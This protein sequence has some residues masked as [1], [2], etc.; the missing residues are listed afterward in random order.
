LS[1]EPERR[2]ASRRFGLFPKYAAALMGLVGGALVLSGLTE[3]GLSYRASMGTTA[4]LQ[5]SEVRAAAIR[6]EQYLEGIRAQVTEVSSL[7]WESGLLDVRDRR[8]EFHRLL[9]EL[10][11]SITILVVSHDLMV[12]SG[13]ANSV[14]CVN[15]SLH[16]HDK[17]E[18][19]ADMIDMMYRCAHDESC[20]V[21]LVSHG[22]P[23]R[24]LRRHGDVRHD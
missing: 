14:A 2:A 6:I 8:E 3:M 4:E 23:H 21:E 5:R 10:N 20:P 16:Y 7:P 12:V 19:T 24:V 22:V 18:V 9:K 13:F 15:Q 11:R 1:S 17:A